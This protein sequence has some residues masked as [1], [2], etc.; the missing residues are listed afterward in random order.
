[1][2]FAGLLGNEDLK[3]RLTA[4]FRAGKHSHCYILTGPEGSGKKTLAK[5]LSQALQCEAADAPCGRCPICRK[6]ENGTHPDV[7]CVDDPERKTVPV[8][9]IRQLQADAYVRPNE[10]NKKVYIIPRAQDMTDNAQNALL[11]LIEEPPSYAVFLLLTTNTEKLLPTVRSRSVELRLEPVARDQAVMWLSGKCP[12]H[13]RQTLQAAYVRCGGFLGQMLEFVKEHK[14]LPQTEQF[15]S[16]FAANDR[17]ELTRLWCSMEK[18]PRDQL[19][20][21]LSR[22]KQLLTDALMVR[23]G[24]PGSPEALKIGQRRTA[25]DLSCAAAQLQKAMEYCAANVGAG[26]ICGHLAVSL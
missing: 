22:F 9:L 26:H 19:Y 17:Y 12:E 2:G 13:D 7:I 23:S 24:M 3:A 25:Q 20:Q 18:M 10:G 4:S 1:M 16:A 15:V 14:E 5:L 6:T 8:E 11:K 21:C